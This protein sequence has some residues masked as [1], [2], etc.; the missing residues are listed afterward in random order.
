M[1]YR[2]YVG[3]LS[4]DATKED[5]EGL[6]KKYGK[7]LDVTVKTGF[8]F[9]EFSDKIDAED[10]VH[11]INDTRF[12]GQRIVVELAMNRRRDDRRD[13]R[14]KVYRVIVKNI[15]PKTTWQDLKDYMKKAGHV[16][17]ADVL[18][19]RNGEGVVEFSKRE[20]MKYALRKLD[21][22]RLN[23]QRISLH[24][25]VSLFLIL[26]LSCLTLFYF[27]IACFNCVYNH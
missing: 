5:L 18:K 22:G 3:R 7:L 19:G 27:G 9:V 6:F 16:A 11:D 17:F 8:G 4:H 21:D 23:G 25:P 13:D 20:D 12:L 15:P 14:R 26:F 24:E 2:V 10:A 1:G